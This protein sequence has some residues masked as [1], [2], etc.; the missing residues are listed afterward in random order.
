MDSLDRV[1][2]HGFSGYIG[3]HRINYIRLDYI[4]CGIVAY[5]EGRD[6]MC[7]CM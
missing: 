3:F 5:R 4:R 7:D 1:H 6:N 2:R